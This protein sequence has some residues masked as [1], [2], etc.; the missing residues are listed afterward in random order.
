VRIDLR[1]GDPLQDIYNTGYLFKTGGMNWT[2]EPYTSTESLVASAWH[3]KTANA[4]IAMTSTELA[5]PIY[6]L[7]Y[8]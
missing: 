6:I 4:I 7:G 2:Q 3:P 1:K 5:N 8:L